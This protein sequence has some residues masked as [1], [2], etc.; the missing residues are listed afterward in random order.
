L[1]ADVHIPL[2]E[3]IDVPGR[4]IVGGGPPVECRLEFPGDRPGF[5]RGPG[6]GCPFPAPGPPRGGDGPS[7]PP[8]L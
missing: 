7:P 1:H 8:T 4:P 5:G 3:A 2:F 6:K